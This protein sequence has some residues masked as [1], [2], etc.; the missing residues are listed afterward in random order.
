MNG[1]PVRVPPSGGSFPSSLICSRELRAVLRCVAAATLLPLSACRTTLCLYNGPRPPKERLAILT[2]PA[3]VRCSVVDRRRVQD[4]GR[5]EMLP[6][7]HSVSIQYHGK[8]MKTQPTGLSFLAEG[9]HEYELRYRMYRVSGNRIFSPEYLK[10][11]VTSPKEQ[12]HELLPDAVFGANRWC[13]FIF[14]VTD[15]RRVTL[16]DRKKD[17]EITAVLTVLGRQDRL[18][19]GMKAVQSRKNKSGKD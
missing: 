14:D 10:M 6:G 8:K 5:I 13:P 7:S 3:E 4:P 19:A 12:R 2:I 9:G 18:M 17:A 16:L 1:H 15:R 11:V